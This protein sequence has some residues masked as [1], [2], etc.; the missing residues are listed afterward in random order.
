LVQE[1]QDAHY[2]IDQH[3][4]QVW[5]PPSIYW[6]CN[7]RH[8]YVRITPRKCK[9]FLPLTQTKIKVESDGEMK[10]DDIPSEGSRVD[11]S[12]L[13]Q[14][15]DLIAVNEKTQPEQSGKTGGLIITYKMKD[16]RTF[17]QK[18]SKVSGAELA[19]ALKTLKIKDTEELQKDWYH[20]KL[21]H[22]RIG[23]PRMIPVS[24]VKQ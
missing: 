22:M 10:I 18:Y 9:D 1:E 2:I 14:E 24:K 6:Y 16:D 3:H 11:L 20:Y 17:Q 23:F 13:P 21:T 19:I 4:N 15:A 7:A 8:C 5:I 12:E